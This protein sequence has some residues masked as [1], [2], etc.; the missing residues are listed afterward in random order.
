MSRVWSSSLI[1][2]KTFSSLLWKM[3][4]SRCGNTLLGSEQFTSSIGPVSAASR[5]QQERRIG[6]LE[7]VTALTEVLFFLSWHATRLLR[8]RSGA[9]KRKVVSSEIAFE[10][11][12]T[13][14]NQALDFP[15]LIK[16]AAGRETKASERSPWWKFTPR[17]RNYMLCLLTCS[18]ARSQNIFASRVD[19]CIT[20][21]WLLIV[22]QPSG[23]IWL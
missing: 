3:P 10:F 22:Q 19:L 15:S 12:E 6:L 1:Q 11:L 17:P 14:D 8:E 9:S 4:E 16:R 5:A 18:A 2:T 21:K 20:I 7:E 13:L 23:I